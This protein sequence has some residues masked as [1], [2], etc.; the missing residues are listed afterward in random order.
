MKYKIYFLFLACNVLFGSI[1]ALYTVDDPILY[2]EWKTASYERVAEDAAPAILNYYKIQLEAR[3]EAIPGE[4]EETIKYGDQLLKELIDRRGDSSS[5][6]LNYRKQLDQLPKKGR[7]LTKKLINDIKALSKKELFNALQ[8]NKKKLDGLKKELPTVQGALEVLKNNNPQEAKDLIEDIAKG[9]TLSRQHV[10]IPHIAI[11]R[12]VDVDRCPN[13]IYYLPYIFISS[14]FSI[15]TQKKLGQA[16]IF[17]R[18]I[19]G[20]VN[21]F[22]YLSSTEYARD[23]AQ[24]Y[25]HSERA[26]FKKLTDFSTMLKDESFILQIKNSLPM[27]ENCQRLWLNDSYEESGLHAPS[28]QIIDVWA[29]LPFLSKIEV[30]REES[31]EELLYNLVIN[32]LSKKKLQIEKKRKRN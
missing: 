25:A 12:L 26:V 14:S 4:K 7:Q 24:M 15:E 18:G 32:N 22:A 3:E 29:K 6:V 17:Q 8:Q 1:P 5:W 30:S 19:A 21:I 20:S 2:E 31:K 10:G 9:M 27:C 11:A 16:K 23:C 13:V 28:G